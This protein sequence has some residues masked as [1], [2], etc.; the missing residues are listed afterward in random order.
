MGHRGVGR[1]WD[2]GPRRV[3]QQQELGPVL[4]RHLVE[5]GGQLERLGRDHG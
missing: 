3:R 2:R 5:R 4:W 1:V